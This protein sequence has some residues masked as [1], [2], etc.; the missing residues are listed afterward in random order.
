MCD[1]IAVMY[2]GKIMG[3]VTPGSCS[4]ETVGLMMA[5]TDGETEKE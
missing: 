2:E 5:G 1:E 4:M 3:I